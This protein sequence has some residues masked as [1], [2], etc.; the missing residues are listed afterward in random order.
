MPTC[1]LQNLS[2]IQAN[3]KYDFLQKLLNAFQFIKSNKHLPLANSFNNTNIYNIL[4][5]CFKKINLS[6]NPIEDKGLF[7]LAN[8]F[9][10]F[11]QL[12]N[13]T[14]LSFSKCSIS[15]KG[16][17]NFFAAITVDSTLSSLDLSHNYLRDE[18][19]VCF[20]IIINL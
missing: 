15:S 16:V 13:L 2:L 4:S 6:R 7:L 18:P 19:T 1:V 5:T 3:L 14:N 20:D 17:N 11:P 12:C 10:E 9:K 8:L